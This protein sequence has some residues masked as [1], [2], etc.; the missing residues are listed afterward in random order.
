MI[1][2]SIYEKSVGYS[3]HGCISECKYYIIKKMTNR[4]LLIFLKLK[5]VSITMDWMSFTDTCN[6]YIRH[7]GLSNEVLVN[8]FLKWLNMSSDSSKFVKFFF[9]LICIWIQFA[10]VAKSFTGIWLVILCYIIWVQ[11]TSNSVFQ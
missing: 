1:Q 8:T 10:I 4:L 3:I 9:L 7:T 11:S 6:Q 5:F 2:Y